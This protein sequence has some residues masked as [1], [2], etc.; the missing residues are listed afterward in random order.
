M[1]PPPLASPCKSP[2]RESSQ[3]EPPE[4]TR[5]AV[6]ATVVSCC[7]LVLSGL[8]VDRNPQSGLW[9]MYQ[10]HPH[11]NRTGSIGH[12]SPCSRAKC[13]SKEPFE[14]PHRRLPQQTRLLHLEKNSFVNAEMLPITQTIYIKKE[15]I[16]CLIVCNSFV[17]IGRNLDLNEV[18]VSR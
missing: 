15:E 4:K 7:E 13:L 9:M 2:L 11:I 1:L 6:S 17:A 10:I 12:Q 5:R 3:Q 16:R 14:I 18:G 8:L